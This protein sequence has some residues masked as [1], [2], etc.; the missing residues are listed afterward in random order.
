MLLEP[1]DVRRF[2]KV[3]ELLDDNTAQDMIDTAEARARLLAPCLGDLTDDPRIGSGLTDDELIVVRDLLRDAVVRWADGGRGIVAA[4]A[5]GE[6]SETLRNTNTLGLFRPNDIRE[7]QS[8]CKG[9]KRRGKASTVATWIGLEP[10]VPTAHP[11]VT[12][13]DH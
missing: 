13:T 5:K 1:A 12:D 7:L 10:E 9:A 11:F 3:P 2:V 8:I 6:Y 4:Q